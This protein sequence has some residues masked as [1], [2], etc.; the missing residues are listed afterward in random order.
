MTAVKAP[1]SGLDVQLLKLHR[2]TAHT[3]HHHTAVLAYNFIVDIDPDN[4]IGTHRLGF[5]FHLIKRDVPRL[6]HLL[7]IGTG[8]T[9]H[10]I[11]NRTEQSP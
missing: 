4:P 8:T 3:H 7:L 9:T 6:T 1:A 11:A 5:G 2:R 10:H